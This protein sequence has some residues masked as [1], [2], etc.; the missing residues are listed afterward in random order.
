VGDE[1]EC[2]SPT[3]NHGALDYCEN[4]VMGAPDPHR[5]SSVMGGVCIEG[6]A[7]QPQPTMP[8]GSAAR[9][10]R[11][12]SG[13]HFT[14]ETEM[15]ELITRLIAEEDGATII[16]YVLLAALI[17]IVAIGAISTIGSNV[18]GKYGEVSTAVGTAAPQ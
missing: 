16:E 6:T 12:H 9:T 11:H 4:T 8:R 17:S 1:V 7:L 3:R 2:L 14:K 13:A 5:N 15:K 10:V 18:K